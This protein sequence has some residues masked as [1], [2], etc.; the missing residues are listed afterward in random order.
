ME[1]EILTSIAS[2]ELPGTLA[3]RQVTIKTDAVT[4]DI[5]LLLSLKAMKKARVKLDLVN[6]SAKIFGKHIPLNH[7]ESRHY[8]IPLNKDVLPIETVWAVNIHNMDNVAR[9]KTL[10]KLRNQFAHLPATTL[11]SLLKDANAWSNE[12]HADIEKIS[13]DCLICKSIAQTPPRP[14]V[15]FQLA[16]N[17]NEKVA[18]DLKNWGK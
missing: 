4:S 13:K 15:N 10:S 16:H 9:Y 3:E 12:F 14:V 8:C 5:P 7:T 1:K 6:H 11:I 18:M 17:F 2:L